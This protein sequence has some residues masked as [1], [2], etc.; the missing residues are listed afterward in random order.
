M[1]T[2]R[3]Q[4]GIGMPAKWKQRSGMPWHITRNRRRHRIDAPFAIAHVHNP[5]APTIAAETNARTAARIFVSRF[6]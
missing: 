5:L 3:A 2:H 4:M 6:I 1:A